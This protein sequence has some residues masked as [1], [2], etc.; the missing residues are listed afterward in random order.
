MEALGRTADELE[1]NDLERG[2]VIDS[3]LGVPKK[4]IRKTIAS[5]SSDE[6]GMIAR[7]LKSISD[8]SN[9]WTA[10]LF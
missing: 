1:G 2:R 6:R 9:T 5:S 4:S 7:N 8:G 10:L 3:Y